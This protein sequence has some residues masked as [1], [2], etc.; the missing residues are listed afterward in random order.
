VNE[1]RIMEQL[2]RMVETGRI[3]A[4]EAQRLRKTRGTAEFAAALNE[5]RARHAAVH[6]D[7]AVA[8]NGMS[9]EEAG[10]YVERIR[11][12]E[13]SRQLRSEIRG[14]DEPAAPAEPVRR[15]APGATR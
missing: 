14:S 8:D 15:P 5:V 13:H 2:D 6:L 10:A 4:A 7:R 12:G 9:T 11:A 3:T 1:E